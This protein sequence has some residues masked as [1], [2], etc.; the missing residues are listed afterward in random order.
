MWSLGAQPLAVLMHL[1]ATALTY[2]CTVLR[3][4]LTGEKSDEFWRLTIDS[5]K[6]SPLTFPLSVFYMKA[7]INSSKFYWSR[8]REY[9]IRQILSHFSTIKVLHYMVH[10]YML[11]SIES[12][13]NCKLCLSNDTLSL[14]CGAC[15]WLSLWNEYI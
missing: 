13:I 11:S 7:T 10:R 3:K 14:W 4:T 8:F 5:S 12:V 2:I 9:S 6:F 1:L 15:S